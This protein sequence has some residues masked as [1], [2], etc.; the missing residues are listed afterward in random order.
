MTTIP[1]I[2]MRAKLVPTRTTSGSPPMTR[3]SQ[4]ARRA[5]VRPSTAA[6]PTASRIACTPARAAPRLSFSPVRRATIAVVDIA[7]PT[8]IE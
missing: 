8:A 1:P 7:S 4:G 5:P 3:S 2:W 6:M